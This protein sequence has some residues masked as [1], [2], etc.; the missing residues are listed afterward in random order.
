MKLRPVTYYLDIAGISKELNEG[1]GKEIDQYSKLAIFEKEKILY[2]GFIAQEVEKAASQA[3][4]DF[5]G[6][7]RPKN[8]KDFYGLR[9]AEFVVPLVK[10]IQEQQVMIE[11]LQKNA[12]VGKTEDSIQAGNQ[13][14]L[15][16]DLQ[17][18]IALLEE[19]N[20]LLNQ[21]L[22]KKTTE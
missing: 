22:N 9:Y 16:D 20:R 8:E 2:S 19:Q 13:M 6:V 18:K 5:S 4:Y 12:R 14:Q 7:D 10:A 15:I 3:G 17:K 1:R 11:G 21:L